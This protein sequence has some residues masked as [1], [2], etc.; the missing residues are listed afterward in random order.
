MSDPDRVGEAGADA[1]LVRISG[2]VEQWPNDLLEGKPLP[3]DWVLVRC[4][5]RREKRLVTELRR[6]GVPGCIFYERRLRNY[7]NKGSQES[8][9]PLLGGYVFVARP[10]TQR[11]ELLNSDKVFQTLPVHDGPKL[12][13]ELSDLKRLLERCNEAPI[14]RPEIVPGSR[15]VITHGALAGCAGVVVERAGRSE[16]AVNLEVLG[17]SVATRLSATTTDLVRD[18]YDE[19]SRRPG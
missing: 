11:Y 6:D 10:W 1:T 2:E 17:T 16:L 12:T 19:A 15:V 3:G 8:L 9:V 5:P 13:R 4:Y 7:R 14:V 18:G